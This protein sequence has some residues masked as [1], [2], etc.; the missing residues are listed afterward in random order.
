M[1]WTT[2][3]TL[4]AGIVVAGMTGSFAAA[5]QTSN[6]PFAAL[7]PSL[8]TILGKKLLSVDGSAVTLTALEGALMRETTGANG[9]VRKTSFHFITDQLGTVTDPRDPNK[10]LGVFRMGKRDV[11]VQYADGGFETMYVSDEG[12]LLDEIR[13]PQSTALCTVWYPEGHVFSL[14]ERKAAV[15]QY[16]SRLG[17]EES[18]NKEI[19]AR[20]SDPAC[21]ARGDLAATAQTGNKPVLSGGSGESVLAV[22]LGLAASATSPNAPAFA[23]ALAVAQGARNADTAAK[24]TPEAGTLGTR[25]PV[26]V[27]P[28]T[29]NRAASDQLAQSGRPRDAMVLA[30]DG[31][32]KCLSVESERGYRGFRNYCAYPVQYAYCV[33]GRRLETASCQYGAVQGSTEPW[34][35]T[36]IGDRPLSP[37]NAPVELRWI[38]CRGRSG[39]VLPRLEQIDPPSGHCVSIAH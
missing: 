1:G 39:D 2:S 30:P 27:P 19:A 13:A 5:P 33:V 23:S 38:A 6:L 24:E 28:Q 3:S 17:V 15:A 36:A 26:P 25:A 16:A 20:K 34:G 12:G 7:S 22:G 4:A 35:F 29:G 21:G 8:D 32:S 31:A 18:G 10:P 11:A 37:A 9:A 14:E